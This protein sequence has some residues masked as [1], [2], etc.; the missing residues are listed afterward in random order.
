YVY[1]TLTNVEVFKSII[2][3]LTKAEKHFLTFLCGR[4]GE[5]DWKEVKSAGF[6]KKILQE[7]HL[8]GLVFVFP[9]LK[10]PKQV[11]LPVEYR[12]LFFSN[13]RE[14][15]SV[16]YAFRTLGTEKVKQITDYLNERFKGNFDPS[17][18]KA[19]NVGFLY[20]FLM[21]KGEEIKKTLTTKQKEIIEFVLQRGNE[22]ELEILLDQ[23]TTFNI[24]AWETSIKT[25]FKNSF[26][27]FQ[28]RQHGKKYTELQELFH[29][30]VLIFTNP[31]YS[32]NVFIPKEIF[33]VMARE[34]LVKTEAK[35]QKV[36]AEMLSGIPGHMKCKS[37]DSLLYMLTK[38]IINFLVLSYIRPTQKGLIPKTAIKKCARILRVDH[39]EQID[40]LSIFLLLK[41]Y[42]T[43]KGKK[44]FVPT[45]KGEKFLSGNLSVMDFWK[46]IEDFFLITTDWNELYKSPNRVLDYYAIPINCD[47][48]GLLYRCMKGIS[49]QWLKAE[50]F[51][52]M[53]YAGYDFTKISNIY[54]NLEHIQDEHY[55]TLLK[56]EFNDLDGMYA[57]ILQTMYYLG[58][59]DIVESEKGITH[60]RLSR[61]AIA[62]A[63]N[64]TMDAGQKSVHTQKKII[65]QPNGEIVCMPGT[66]QDILSELGR[67]AEIKK[68]DHTIIFELSSQSVIKGVTEF[69]LDWAEIMKFLTNHT[70]KKLPQNIAYLFKQLKE[71]EDLLTVGRCGGYIMVK[72]RIL[73][74]EIKNI[75]SIKKHIADS[76]ELPVLILKS[77]AGIKEVLRELRK[78]GHLPKEAKDMEPEP[79]FRHKF[80]RY[81]EHDYF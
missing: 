17:L 71:K 77:D 42:V 2:S 73:L 74:E 25:I 47:F 72:D 49:H 38:N 36:M 64:Q 14:K 22:V 27:R 63:T 57:S 40:C 12:Y 66:Q 55:P 35:K 50:K 41:D 56:S 46:E 43:S 79:V 37:I 53:L 54:D 7:L 39:V 68:I 62:L 61:T 34:Y 18:S 45:Q 3:S 70:G 9:D 29:M 69:K 20:N 16:L 65:L 48:K 1:R 80:D 33:P 19:S 11:I 6:T 67:F 51:R 81:E 44:C 59:L 76:S 32:N 4:K 15:E 21:T 31:E 30:G 58:L 8:F 5:V 60:I 26:H 13:N 10:N 23:F 78:K 28:A 52:E 24:H 75:K